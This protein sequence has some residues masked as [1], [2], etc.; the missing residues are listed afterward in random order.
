MIIIFQ[1]EK[2]RS[3]YRESGMWG[4]WVTL[5]LNRFISIN[6]PEK[7]LL[8]ADIRRTRELTMWYWG[9]RF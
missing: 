6:L 4:F 3:G 7:K 2:S 1:K 5:A 8:T 9:K